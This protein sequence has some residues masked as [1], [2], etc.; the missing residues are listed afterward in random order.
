[1]SEKR[2]HPSGVAQPRS[3]APP[4]QGLY[5]PQ[6]EHEACGVGFLVNIK[7]RK[8]HEI[9][10]HALTIL[11]NLNHRGACGC[12]VN[13]GDGAGIL[14]QT[15]HGF[16]KE[17]CAEANVPLP[18]AGDYGVGLIY[19]PQDPAERAECEKIFEQIIEAEGQR[20]LGWRTVPTSNSDLGATAK[21]SEPAMRQV[22]IGRGPKM[23]DALAF[24]RKLYVIRKQ[25]E[26]AIRYSGKVQGGNRFYVASLS[27]KTLIYKGML[28][29]TQIETY[30]PDLQHPAMETG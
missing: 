12:E 20:L 7:G 2:M 21:A 29:P 11:V 16:L 6:F 9:V 19:M 22:F 13:T 15:P 8:S 25:A 27:Y 10:K 24:E 30:F 18:S 28:V 5:D 14:M 17:A 23:G 26:N 4:K 3:V 1:M